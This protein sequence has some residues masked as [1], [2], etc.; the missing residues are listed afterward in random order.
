[1]KKQRFHYR[2]RFPHPTCSQKSTL[3]APRRS[4]SAPRASQELSERS[5]EGPWELSGELLEVPKPSQ[6]DL[7]ASRTLF[8]P[9][10][11]SE[12][13]KERKLEEQ[14]LNMYEIRPLQTSKSTLPCRRELDYRKSSASTTELDFLTPNAPKSRPSAPQ[15]APRAPQELPKSSPSA[16]QRVPGSSLEHS[17]RS[18]IAPKSSTSLKMTLLE[19]KRL[20]PEASGPSFGAFSAYYLIHIWP[21]FD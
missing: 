3:S 7:R 15:D 18:Q 17:W 12:F 16:P 8:W 20:P 13:K 19:L 5:P 9:P 14:F 11:R 21:Q 1:M 4:Q 6:G 10:F 2:A